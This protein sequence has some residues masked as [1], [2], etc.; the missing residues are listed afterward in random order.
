MIMSEPRVKNISTYHIP[1]NGEE[2]LKHL[3]IKRTIERYMTL[4]L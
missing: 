1:E 3:L 2:R 4:W